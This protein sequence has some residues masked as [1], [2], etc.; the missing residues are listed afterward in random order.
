MIDVDHKHLLLP[1]TQH[2][3]PAVGGSPTTGVRVLSHPGRSVLHLPTPA[4][5]SS[6]LMRTPAAPPNR[7]HTG[8]LVC[9]ANAE[10]DVVRSH[11]FDAQ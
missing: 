11:L 9:A 7:T 5:A 1:D 2:T 10:C 4:Y 3:V 6:V 8:T